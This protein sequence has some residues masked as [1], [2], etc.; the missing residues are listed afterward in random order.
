MN[1]NNADELY[2]INE[3]TI[4]DLVELFELPK[5]FN[6]SQL[7][8]QFILFLEENKNVNEHIIFLKD[9]Y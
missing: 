6:S 8:S 9:A 7:D 3:Y 4:S 1:K 5:G 2:D